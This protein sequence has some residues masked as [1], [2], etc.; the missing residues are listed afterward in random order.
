M[1]LDGF[2]RLFAEA[3][4][5]EPRMPVSVAGGDDPTVLAALR[6]ATDRGWLAPHVVGP[7]KSVRLTARSA[8]VELDGFV[9][10]DAEGDALA[11]MAVSLVREGPARLLMKGK[12][13]T[14]SLLRAVLDPVHGLRNGRVVCQVVLME[15]P[16]DGRVFLLADTGITVRPNLDQK[17]DILASA[18]EVATALGSGWPRVAMMAA[19]ETINPAMPDTL[20]AAELQSRNAAGSLTGCV[21]QGPLSFDLAYAAGAA[22]RKRIGGEVAGSAN[23]MIFP[24][25]LSANLTVKAI[26]YTAEC[27]FGGVLR[28]TS[29]PVVFMSRADSASTRLNS[30]S[31]ALR[32]LARERLY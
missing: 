25:L 29:A 1:S 9:L 15:I 3:D 30:L 24:D 32:I 7:E 13:A 16:R 18:V 17:A 5:R 12:I 10:H 26:M 6:E 4:A 28:G 20:E 31:L 19:T 27:R 11:S 23:V 14:P 22:D 2:D 8:G 21:V